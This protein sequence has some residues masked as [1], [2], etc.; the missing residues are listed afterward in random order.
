MRKKQ[1]VSQFSVYIPKRKLGDRIVERIV[2][3]G[4]ARQRSVNFLCV[5]AI[6]EYLERQEAA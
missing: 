6:T 2:T 4:D 3:L 5:E 1:T